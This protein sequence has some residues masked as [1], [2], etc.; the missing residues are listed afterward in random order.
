MKKSQQLWF[1]EN[2]GNYYLINRD[3]SKKC[4]HAGELDKPFDA[5][6]TGRF[7]FSNR[8]QIMKD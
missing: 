7:N 6:L 2:T 3:N 4:N 1:T 8:Y 5:N